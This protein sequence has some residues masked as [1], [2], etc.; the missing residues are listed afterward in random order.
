MGGK[1]VVAACGLVVAVGLTAAPNGHRPPPPETR[2]EP[3]YATVTVHGRAGSF[4]AMAGE[5]VTPSGQDV[6]R[7][8]VPGWHF[9][10]GVQAYRTALA[11]DGTLLIAGFSHTADLSAPTADRTV[12]GAYQPA[13]GVF[14]TIGIGPVG[15]GAPSVTDLLPVEGG[16]AFTTRRADDAAPGA[17]P[18]FG[19]LSKVGGRWRVAPTAGS[20]D[21][22]DLHDLARLPRSRDIVVARYGRGESNGSLLALRLTG[23]DRQGRFTIAVMGEYRYP[24]LDGERISVRAIQADPTGRDGDERFAVGLDVYRG[25][26]QFP[27]TVVQEFS[28][29]APSGAIRPIS[30]PIV[31]GDRN[32]EDDA[33]YASGAFLY[34]HLGNLWVSR[35]DGFQGGRLAVYAARDG[36]RRLERGECRLRPGWAQHRYHTSGNGKSVWGL[37]CRPDYDIVQADD[38]LTIEDLAQDPR[39]KAVLALSFGGTV[40]PIR[41]DRAG[42]GLTFR[43]GTPVDLGRKLLPTV[44]GNVDDHRLGPVDA[45]GRMWMAAMHARPGQAGVSLDQWLYSVDVADLVAPAPVRLPDTPGRSVTVQAE[46]TR[47]TGTDTR[48]G[49]WAKLEVDARTYVHTCLDWPT[50]TTCGYDGVAGNGFVLGDDSGYGVLDGSVEY[51]VDVPVAGQYQVSYRVATFAVTKD[52]RIEFSAGGRRHVDPVSTGGTW[53]TVRAADPVT[54][55]AGRQTITLSV[56]KGGGGWY[57]NWLTLQRL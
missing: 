42:D 1:R 14:R 33:F 19:V 41:V 16:V 10:P 57:L 23:P 27:H 31:P 24:V 30:A 15:P 36:R 26:G 47:T 2:K 46:R 39:T 9:P 8:E 7:V 45:E 38:V 32:P 53:R 11:A 56:P 28:Y 3:V 35:M 55:P 29:E 6:A 17:W 52:A 18:G 25:R 40:L 48:P 21:H 44:V 54:L 5:T 49:R 50:P 51:A 12:V 13:K 34:D 37:T 20:V 4:G 43:T 22:D